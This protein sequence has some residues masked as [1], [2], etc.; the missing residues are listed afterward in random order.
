MVISTDGI[1]PQVERFA[2]KFIYSKLNTK[3]FNKAIMAMITK[4]EKSMGNTFTIVANTAL[5]AEVQEVLGAWLADHKTDGA[6]LWSRKS[7]GYVEVGA[8]YQAYEFMGNKILFKH[9]RALDVEFPYRPFGAMIDLTAD[10][11]SGKNVKNVEVIGGENNEIKN[12]NIVEDLTVTKGKVTVD[13]EVAYDYKTAA[14]I[15]NIDVKKDA[16]LISNV[17]IYVTNIAN[18]SGAKTTVAE[19]YTIWYTNVYTQGGSATGSILKASWDGVADQVVP[20]TEGRLTVYTVNKADELVW[21]SQQGQLKNTKVVLG[22]NI[23]MAGV[24]WT[25]GINF[26]AGDFQSHLDGNGF[27]IMNLNGNSGLLSYAV[28]SIKN[29]TIEGVNIASNDFIGA[30]ANNSY[31]LIENVTVKN[32]T[33]KGTKR[34]GAIVGIHNGG[35]M[36]NCHVENASISGDCYSAGVITGMVNESEGQKFESCTIKNSTVDAELKGAIAGIINGVTLTVQNITIENT[37]PSE[38]VGKLYNGGK[39]VEVK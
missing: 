11:N 12:V 31:A 30:L 14:T 24:N 23:N 39:L 3:L 9:D 36:K 28:G 37:T 6:A 1:I 17:D 29:L 10:V 21:L 27:A 8:T 35:N 25:K 33:V 5:M 38:L 34:V 26:G 20:T 15:A 13:A 2:N 32:V 22:G 16:E 19:P 7:N 4:C 18:P